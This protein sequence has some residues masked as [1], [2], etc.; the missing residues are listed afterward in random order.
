MWGHNDSTRRSVEVLYIKSCGILII[1]ETF[2]KQLLMK[3]TRILEYMFR[4][5][6]TYMRGKFLHQEI[7]INRSVQEYA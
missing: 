1:V 6:T 5:Y 7:R 2:H 3:E 4:I